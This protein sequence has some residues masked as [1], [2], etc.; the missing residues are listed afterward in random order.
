LAIRLQGLPGWLCMGRR[1][2]SVLIGINAYLLPL[3]Q[4]NCT[5]SSGVFPLL[6][7]S[8][9]GFGGP[10]FNI[11]SLLQTC[12]RFNSSYSFLYSYLNEFINHSQSHPLWCPQ[13]IPIFLLTSLSSHCSVKTLCFLSFFLAQVLVPCAFNSTFIT[14]IAILG[15]WA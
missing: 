7:K 10:H 1:C 5:C 2:S 6:P 13:P 14:Q 3:I 8:Y 9:W 12:W 11:F 4:H 15:Q